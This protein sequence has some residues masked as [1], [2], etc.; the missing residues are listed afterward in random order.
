MY[1]KGSGGYQL[2][3]KWVGYGAKD[4]TWEQMEPF[5]SNYGSKRSEIYEQLKTVHID[6]S[7]ISTFDLIAGKPKNKTVQPKPKPVKKTCV[8][9]M[10]KCPIDHSLFGISYKEINEPAEVGKTGILYKQKC[11]GKDCDNVFGEN[12][13][14][15]MFTPVY[16]CE[17]VV[18][19]CRHFLCKK[20]HTSGLLSMTGSKRSRRQ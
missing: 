15:T 6:V 5:L 8:Q 12:Y 4:N 11:C 18:A 20:C 2:L 19:G 10:D 16:A 14:V 3:V 1:Q 13:A 17:R 9:V 7:K